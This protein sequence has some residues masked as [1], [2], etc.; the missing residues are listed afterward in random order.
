MCVAVGCV[1]FAVGSDLIVVLVCGVV[2]CFDV[3][4]VC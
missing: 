1:V 2:F 3:V 4:D